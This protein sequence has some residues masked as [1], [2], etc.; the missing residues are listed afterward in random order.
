MLAFTSNTCLRRPCDVR[1]SQHK[2]ENEATRL[3]CKK[4]TPG[5]NLELD[6]TRP[7]ATNQNPAFYISQ[8]DTW[9]IAVIF[10]DFDQWATSITAVSWLRPMSDQYHGCFLTSTNAQPV[11]RLFLA[12]DPII[13][14]HMIQ[15]MIA[16]YF[17]RFQSK[18]NG[19]LLF[20]G[21]FPKANGKWLFFGFSPRVQ[22]G[23]RGYRI[24][25]INFRIL[26]RFL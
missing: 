26:G 3:V 10:L 16:L 4:K 12:L 6:A 20:H 19:I 21:F 2:K 9:M 14:L 1:T 8:S 23:G 15:P 22:R 7:F 24:S 5:Y 17:R 18:A 11:L 13:E 25:W